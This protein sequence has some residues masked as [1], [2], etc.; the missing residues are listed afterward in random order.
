MKLCYKDTATFVEVSA[1]GYGNNKIVTDQEA[2]PVVFLQSTGFTR[3]EYQ[4]NTDSDAICYVDP[5]DLWVVATHNRME[6]F[7]ILAPLFSVD[8]DDGWYKVTKVIVNRDHLLSNTIDNIQLLL[9]KT[10]RPYGYS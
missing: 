5:S 6:G 1:S 4:E 9:K 10:K 8:S 3:S 7:Y 2:V